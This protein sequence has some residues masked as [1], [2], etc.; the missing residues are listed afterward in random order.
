MMRRASTTVRLALVIGLWPAVC[1]AEVRFHGVAAGDMTA[2]DVILWTRADDDGRAARVTA[3]VAAD[4]SFTTVIA[5]ATGT[6]VPANNGTLKLAVGGL[7][8]GQTYHYRFID[9]AAPA[10]SSAIGRFTTAPTVAQPGPV[11]FGFSGDTDGMWRPFPS[12]ATIAERRLNFFIFLGDTIYETKSNGSAEVPRLTQADDAAA[13]QGALEAYNRKYAENIQGVSP[14]G[15]PGTDGQPGLAPL[16]LA[17][18]LYVLLDNHELGNRSLQSGGAPPALLESAALP[19]AS[20]F[21]VNATGPFNNQTTGFLT[22]LKAFYNNQPTRVDIAGTP[23]GGDLAATGPVVDAPDDPRSHRTPR[24]FFAQQWGPHA[25]YIQT[26]NRG[27]RDARLWQKPLTDDTGPRADNPD[28]TMLGRTQLAW[29]KQALR[30]AEAAGTT[31]KFVA[32]SSPIDQSGDQQDGKSWYGGY[33]A[34][35]NDLLRFVADEGIRRVVFL[36][37]D[38]HYSRVTRL[39]Y[40]AADGTVRDLPDSF[41]IVAGPI[42]AGGPD[43]NTNHDFAAIRR[44]ATDWDRSTTTAGGPPSGLAGMSGLRGVFREGN[45]DAAASPS[46]ADFF[47]ADTFAHTVFEVAADGVLTVQTWG[48]DSYPRNTFRQGQTVRRLMEFTLAP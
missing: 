44:M 32:L 36:T 42:G 17:T 24:H 19:A 29:L 16:F 47:S 39:R 34:E 33:R 45:P 8:S 26:D 22:L 25:V 35:R 37:T 5:T 12:I 21:D 46:P 14:D 13:W 30:A 2:T 9:A 7:A 1:G 38:D 10:T 48:I 43:R 28:R 4:T 15:T 31:W 20:Q 23:A 40:T 18:G 41:L 6:T 11:R 27:Y 3:Q